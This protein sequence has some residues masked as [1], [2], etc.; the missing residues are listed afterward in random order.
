MYSSDV[1]KE[2]AIKTKRKEEKKKEEKKKER[3]GSNLTL[4]Y[5]RKGTRS[6]LSPVLSF[7]SLSLI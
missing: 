6:G 1:P 5:G 4:R 7:M 2:E 3:K